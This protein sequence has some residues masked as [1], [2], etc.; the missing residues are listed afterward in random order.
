MLQHITTQGTQILIKLYL[1]SVFVHL[2]YVTL[3]VSVRSTN[4][5]IK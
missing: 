2:L 1:E 3:D 5:L 4:Q